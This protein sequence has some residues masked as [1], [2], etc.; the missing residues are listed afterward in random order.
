MP[1]KPKCTSSRKQDGKNFIAAF[2]GT[3]DFDMNSRYQ[4]IRPIGHGAYGAVISALDKSLNLHVAIKK[5]PHTF[6][7]LQSG[8]IKGFEAPRRAGKNKI[9]ELLA[10]W[11]ASTGS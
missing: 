3:P 2:F 8:A 5:I 7:D 4:M 10:G 1:S 11:A 6:E 9:P